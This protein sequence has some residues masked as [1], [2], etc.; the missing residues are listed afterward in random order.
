[1][2]RAIQLGILSLK[3]IIYF[4]VN[5]KTTVRSYFTYLQI[6][7]LTQ[8]VLMQFQNQTCFVTY[9]IFLFECVMC[10]FFLTLEIDKFDILCLVYS[11]FGEH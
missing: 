11:N 3:F 6:G 5:C 4:H 10:R 2:A 9:A 8:I 7:T 1:M